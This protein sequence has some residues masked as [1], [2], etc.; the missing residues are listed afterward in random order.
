MYVALQ[1][2]EKKTITK[3][4]NACKNEEK[5]SISITMEAK[6]ICLIALQYTQSHTYPART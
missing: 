5:V 2:K 4:F 6:G 1:R 3:I